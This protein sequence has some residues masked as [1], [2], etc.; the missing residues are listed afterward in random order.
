MFITSF[1]PVSDMYICPGPFLLKLPTTTAI[2]NLKIHSKHTSNIYPFQKSHIFFPGR[3]R[4][5][6]TRFWNYAHGMPSTSITPISHAVSI[7]QST[8]H[9]HGMPST[10][11]RLQ[12]PPITPIS[13]AVSI[14]HATPTWHSW[15]TRQTFSS[16]DGA[17]LTR[18]FYNNTHAMFYSKSRTQKLRYPPNETP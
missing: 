17:I 10:E 7:R 4:A 8:T 18:F 14:C 16:Q 3:P 11:R 5:I 1:F 12:T 15:P 2:H 9:T 6:L 13:H